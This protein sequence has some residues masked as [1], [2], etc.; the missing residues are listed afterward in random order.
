MG[1]LSRNKTPIEDFEGVIKDYKESLTVGKGVFLHPSGEKFI[2]VNRLEISENGKILVAWTLHN[3]NPHTAQLHGFK[4]IS[5]NGKTKYLHRAIAE[6]FI[7]NP[8]D[9]TRVIH[10]DG[11]KVN[12]S[13]NNLEWR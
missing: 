1:N 8:Y 6:T 2:V 3:I 12:N 4:V 5:F 7:P 13:V 11:N 10:K 9:C